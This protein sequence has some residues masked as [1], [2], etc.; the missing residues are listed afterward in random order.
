MMPVF[1][2]KYLCT[3]AGIKRVRMKYLIVGLGN[4]GVEYE[5]TRHNIGFKALDYFAEKHQVSFTSDRY[6]FSATFRLKGRILHLIK[7][8]TYMNLS[9]KAV[10]Y[11]MEKHQIPPENILIITDDKDLPLGSWKVKSQGSGGTHNGLNHI[12]ETINTSYFSR[13]RLG[14]GSEFAKGYQVEYVLGTFTKEEWLNVQ[15][16]IETSQK[17][18]ESF[19]LQGIQKTMNIYNTKKNERL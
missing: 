7:P 19:V 11:Y 14:I 4:I 13:L 17:I 1:C 18:I 12:I 8:T 16:A 2:F 3:F 6:A 9:G 5:N 15:P 10:R